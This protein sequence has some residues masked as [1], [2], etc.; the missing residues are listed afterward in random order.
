[1]GIGTGPE[2][3]NEDKVGGLLDIIRPGSDV[4]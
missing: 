3:T 2:D 4:V 1:M